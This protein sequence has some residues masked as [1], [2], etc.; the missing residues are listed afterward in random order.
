MN[1]EQIE[2]LIKE[3]VK[4]YGETQK[5]YHGDSYLSRVIEGEID[6]LEIMLK[7]AKEEQENDKSR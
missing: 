6:S 2:K 1:I 3:K 5:R 7:K 4:Q